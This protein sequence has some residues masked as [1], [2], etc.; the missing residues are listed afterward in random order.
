[1]K[2]LGI[3]GYKNAGKTS[4]VERLVT[5]ITGRGYSVSTVKHAHHAFDLDQPGKD[6]FRHRAAGARQVM[7]ATGARWVLMSELR[8]MPEPPLADLLARLDPV[9]LVLVE[10]Y[11]RDSHRKIEV[12]RPATGHPLIA[13][14]DPTVIAVATDG[15]PVVDVPCLDLND[16]GA[17]ADF[18]LCATGLVRETGGLFDSFLMVDWSGGNDTGSIPRKD[19]IWA[20]LARDGAAEPPAYLRNRQVAEVWI[21]DRIAEEIAAG[22][23][24]CVGFDFPFATP[25]GFASSLTGQDNPLALWDWFAARVQDGPQGNNRF[26]LAG[27]INAQFPGVGPFWG[28][29]LA[30]NIADLPRKGNARTFRWPV[31]KRRVE[32]RATGAFECWQLSGAGAVGSQMI[33]GLPVLARLRQRFAGHVT[34]WPFEAGPAPVTF[35]EIW[36]SL[37]RQAV[38]AA[39][40]PGDIKDAVQVRLLALSMARLSQAALI[41]MLDRP[42]DPEGWIFGVDHVGELSDAAF[43]VIADTGFT[44]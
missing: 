6:T 31:A 8:D 11:K 30:R 13:P 42:P 25:A 26:D 35:M 19:A 22:R 37:I 5:E 28:N 36:P 20:C 40:R 15:A 39:T 7:L 29:G 33:M 21:G 16:T 24:V 9:D 32:A 12:H 4:L 23:R 34:V 18:V 43:A 2:V 1:M 17:V 41:R 44:P 38:Q 10:G 27:Q 14:G 3:I